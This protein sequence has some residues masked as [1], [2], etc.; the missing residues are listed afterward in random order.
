MYSL[1]VTVD[2]RADMV[3]EFVA[4]ISANANASLRD[5]PGCLSFDIHRDVEQ[6][7]RFYFYEVYTDETAFREGHL[8]SAHYAT[9]HAAAEKLLE[10]GSQQILFADVIRYGAAEMV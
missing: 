6:P 10:A 5:E 3:D 2:V 7:T 1:F 9:W 8:G 4:A